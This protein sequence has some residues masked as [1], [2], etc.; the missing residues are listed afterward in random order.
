VVLTAGR[1]SVQGR[2]RAVLGRKR[3]CAPGADAPASASTLQGVKS[4]AEK[5][6]SNWEDR[7]EPA[8]RITLNANGWPSASTPQWLARLQLLWHDINGW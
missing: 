2:L 3:P 4:G 6:R 5:R 8:L 1:G 7:H